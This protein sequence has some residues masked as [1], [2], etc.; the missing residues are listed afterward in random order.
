MDT[1][2]LAVACVFSLGAVGFAIATYSLLCDTYEEVRALRRQMMPPPP[3]Q[4]PAPP[5]FT[6]R[7][8]NF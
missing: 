3:G 6:P 2:I 8:G 7:P 1:V 5:P 4:P